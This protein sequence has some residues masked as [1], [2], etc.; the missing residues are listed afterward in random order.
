[1]GEEFENLKSQ[2]ERV[3]ASVIEGDQTDCTKPKVLMD[4]HAILNC[5]K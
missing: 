4:A 5:N 3:Q 2:I 1:M